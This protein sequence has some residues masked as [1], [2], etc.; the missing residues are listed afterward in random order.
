MC[1]G[2]LGKGGCILI[3]SMDR[4]RGQVSHIKR[5]S[6]SRSF[7]PALPQHKQYIRW[8]IMCNHTS[9]QHIYCFMNFL[10]ASRAHRQSL[11]TQSWFCIIK[12]CSVPSKAPMNKNDKNP[13]ALAALQRNNKT[14]NPTG[15]F[16]PRMLS[17]YAMQANC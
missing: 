15:H 12:A 14:S 7:P 1:V 2:H 10:S 5:H 17:M 11:V 4:G 16:S 9:K 3:R 13:I 8:R 6:E